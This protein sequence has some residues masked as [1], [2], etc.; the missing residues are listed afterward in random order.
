MDLIM[1]FLFL[2]YL[3]LTSLVLPFSSQQALFLSCL[4]KRSLFC[5]E[6]KLVLLKLA[7]EILCLSLQTS[8]GYSWCTISGFHCCTFRVFPSSAFIN[9]AEINVF[10][11]MSFSVYLESN[12][13][14]IIKNMKILKAPNV[15]FFFF[16]DF[17]CNSH[18]YFGTPFVA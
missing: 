7:Q 18:G 13:I 8:W 14:R 17:F 1:T 11:Y 2:L 12:P 16:F 15:L 5:F 3:P 9:R 4:L 10:W 6:R